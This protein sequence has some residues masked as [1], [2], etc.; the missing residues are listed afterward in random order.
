MAQINIK[1]N[2]SSSVSTPPVGI[3]AIF[4]ADDGGLYTK[5]SFGTVST[6]GGGGSG[7]SGS[8]G[9]SG[10]SGSSGSSGTSGQNGTGGS[11]GTSGIN[12][13]V[14]SSGTS[15]ISGTS[16][17]SP[18]GGGDPAIVLVNTG[19]SG[20]GSLYS[21]AIGAT[22]SEPND[23][24]SI[25]F[26]VNAKAISKPEWGLVQENSI[27]LGKDAD[28]TGR[29][30]ITIGNSA[31]AMGSNVI[32]IGNDTFG[33]DGTI[34][35]GGQATGGSGYHLAIGYQA[36]STGDRNIGIGHQVNSRGADA[37]ALGTLYAGSIDS[38]QYARAVAIGSEAFYGA[39]GAVAVGSNSKSL[40]LNSV[41]IGRGS[42]SSHSGAAV[43]G[44][45]VMSV[46]ADHTHINS[47][48]IANVPT[49]ADNSAA[50]SGGLVAGQVYRTSTGVLMITY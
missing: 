38:G 21:P 26:G 42:T 44:S 11:S 25:V 48:F 5:N 49:Y 19:T 6:I 2:N 45:N 41:V 35:I 7:T 15:G 9:T 14:G 50:T 18:G 36:Y 47:L 43:V 20:F 1:K 22:A 27:V 10:V 3:E 46:V 17:T 40:A 30:N 16:G 31:R 8:S 32:S 13:S 23:N 24:T 28:S 33:E 4:I 34:Q 39:E 29:K 37:V 12:G